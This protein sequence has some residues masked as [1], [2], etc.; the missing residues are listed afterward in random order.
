M[1]YN[2]LVA[3]EEHM[4]EINFRKVTF[5]CMLLRTK[6]TSVASVMFSLLQ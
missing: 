5:V 6:T 4:Y 2:S 3:V 1:S